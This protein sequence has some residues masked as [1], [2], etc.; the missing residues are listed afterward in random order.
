MPTIWPLLGLCDVK[1]KDGETKYCRIRVILNF[2]RAASDTISKGAALYRLVTSVTV[3]ARLKV[4]LVACTLVLLQWVWF[5]VCLLQYKFE[6]LLSWFL[7]NQRLTFEAVWDLCETNKAQCTTVWCVIYWLWRYFAP[8][9]EDRV[10]FCVV[11]QLSTSS[12]K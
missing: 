4:E 9:R 10:D 3:D 1:G 12:N 5:E 2:D 11:V 7:H 6:V 8:M